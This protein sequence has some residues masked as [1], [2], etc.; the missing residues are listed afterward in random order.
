MGPENT[1]VVR[2]AHRRAPWLAATLALALPWALFAQQQEEAPPPPPSPVQEQEEA[3]APTVAPEQEEGATPPASPVKEEVLDTPAPP[4]EKGATLAPAPAPLGNFVARPARFETAPV[5]DGRLDDAVWKTAEHLT[6][7][8]QL[9]PYDGKPA[10]EATEVFL[11]YDQN[12]LYI[13]IRCHD[14]EPKKIVTTT[15]TRDSD[16]TYDDTVQILF[17]TFR[18]RRSAYLFVTNSGGVQVDGLVRSEGEQISLEWDAVWNVRGSKDAGGWSTEME[19][20]WRS[21]RFPERPEQEWGIMIERLVARKQERTF[22]KLPTK[23]WYARW[24]MSEAGT[25][26]GMEGVRPGSRYHFAPYVVGGAERHDFKDSTSSITDIGGDL[27]INLSSDLVADLTYKTDFSET[28][29]D[30]Q[31]VN[32]TRNPLFFPEK[33]SFF[34]EGAS[35][36]YAG[37]RPDPE[38]A[39]EYYLFFSRRIGLSDDGRAPIPILGGAKLT[40]QV[41]KYSVGALAVQTEDIRMADGYGGFIEAPRTNFTVGRVKRDLGNGST[42]GLIGLSKDY[43]GYHNRTFGADWDILLA[44]NLRGGGYLAQSSTP[45]LEGTDHAASANLYYDT[46][47]LR[48][49]TEYIDIGED[50]NNEMGYMGRTGIRSLRT[51][52]FW[53]FWPERGPFKLVWFTYDYDY[54]EDRTTNEIQSRFSHIQYNSYF[55][56]SSGFAYKY[57]IVTEVLT[58]PFEIQKGIVIQPGH[59]DFSYHFFGFQTDYTK[60]LG[61][62]GRVAWG[63][64]YDGHYTQTFY[65]L[66][67]RPIPG[68]IIDGTYQHTQINLSAGRFESDIVLGEVIYAFTNRIAAR[69][70]WQWTKDANTR[71]KFDVTWELKN[72]TKLFFVYQNIDTQIDFFNPRQPLFGIPGR[73]VSLKTVFNL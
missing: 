6:D 38:H 64:Y 42:F 9:E 31:E 24:K 54:I 21:L 48:L 68:L 69:A 70:W 66:A 14:S 59:Y 61:A 4:A 27:K 73:S 1:T 32:L 55:R 44:K 23:S 2:P 65:Y 56:N 8:L 67:Y 15:L 5:I 50:F 11:G 43:D 17:D 57:F 19:I 25:L 47:N 51:D 53:I 28:E 10:T 12:H 58:Q 62:V 60:P 71:Q 46:R 40:G 34:L 18:D 63:E 35:S 26:V 36:F 7:F 39:S 3:A 33:R 20:P 45:G 72:G 52:Y 13:G 41:G 22:W 30:Q 16:M 49:H 29:A 37:Q